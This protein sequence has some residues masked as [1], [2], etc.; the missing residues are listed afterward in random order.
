MSNPEPFSAVTLSEP[1]VR[2][3]RTFDLYAA[4]LGGGDV[5][6]Q[7]ADGSSHRLGSTRWLGRAR[8]ADLTVLNR[9][10]GPVLDVGCGP[11]RFVVA[12]TERGVPALGVDIA[13][14]A[15]RLTQALGAM[16]L[17][18][19]VF[20]SLPGEGRWASVLLA[21]G[22]I[23]IGGDPVRLLR[24]SAQLIGPEGEV[25]VEVHGTGVRTGAVR[26]EHKGQLGGW[27]GWAS[28]GADAIGALARA[29][30]LRPKDAWGAH[31]PGGLRSFVVLTPGNSQ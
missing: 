1:R 19:S 16:A 28:V 24:R 7:H 18:R 4:A 17:H 14:A 20:A 12:L 6:V 30:G 31:E 8:H 21:D 11:G 23:G 26:L 5:R 2:S 29:A 3:A 9:L 10:Q 15:V 25:L 13:P 22:N 27:F